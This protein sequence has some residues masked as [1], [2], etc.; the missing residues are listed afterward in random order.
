MNALAIQIQL[1]L[2]IARI[3]VIRAELP[4]TYYDQV[5]WTPYDIATAPIPA[6]ADEEP[7]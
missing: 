6:F 4:V 1:Q 7:Q 2:L 3:N 5:D